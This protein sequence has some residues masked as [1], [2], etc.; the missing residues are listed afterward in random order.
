MDKNGNLYKYIIVN[1]Q[2]IICYLLNTEPSYGTTMVICNVYPSNVEC[3][4]NCNAIVSYV[5]VAM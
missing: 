1:Y 3:Y 4:C 5:A 2:N